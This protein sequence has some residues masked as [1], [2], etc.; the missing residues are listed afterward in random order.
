M[1]SMTLPSLLFDLLWVVPASL[2]LNAAW[3]AVKLYRIQ[4]D[5]SADAVFVSAAWSTLSLRIMIVALLCW[6]TALLFRRVWK[7]V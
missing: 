4:R 3:F 7:G 1:P 5:P 6:S 2:A